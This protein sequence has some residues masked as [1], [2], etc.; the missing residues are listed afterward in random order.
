MTVVEVAHLRAIGETYPISL[1][2]EAVGENHPTLATRRQ[3]G[4]LNGRHHRVADPQV[5]LP[6]VGFGEGVRLPKWHVLSM[7]LVAFVAHAVH[8]GTA[9]K[10]QSKGRHLG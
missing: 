5:D 2:L 9:R 4:K 7:A 6:L 3:I 1:P 8:S 10:Q